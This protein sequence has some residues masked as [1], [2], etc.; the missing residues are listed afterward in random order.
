M[1]LNEYLIG[2]FGRKGFIGF[3]TLDQMID[4]DVIQVHMLKNK[5]LAYEIVCGIP[6]IF[7]RK[8]GCINRCIA[9]VILTDD[10]LFN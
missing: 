3:V 2:Y 7:C 9:R 8:G 1:Q 5:R 6:E 10:R 4:F